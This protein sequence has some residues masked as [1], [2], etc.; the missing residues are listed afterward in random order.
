MKRYAI[1]LDM[2][3]A[4]VGWAV[5]ALDEEEKPIGIIDLG[6]RIFDAAEQPKTGASLAA[7]RREARGA[8]RRLR[9]H[10]HRNERIRGT[11]LR[12]GLLT[13]QEL[14]QLFDGQLEDIYALRV[15]A[16]DEPVSRQEFARILI[17]LSQH[18]G[19]RSNRRN[20]VDGED[21][22]L[23]T[24]VNE[25]KRIMETE[26]Y[27]TV[28]EMLLKDKRFEEH[29][30]NKGGDYISTVSRDMVE[31]EV[32][33]IFEAQRK[34]GADFADK[35]LESDYIEILLSQRSFDEG[36]GG[37]SPYGGNQIE[38]MIGECTFIEG[39]PR[40][41]KASYSFE[42]FSFLE[43]INH[44]RLVNGKESV[45]LSEAQRKKLIELAHKSDSLNYAKIRKELSIDD[46]YKFN[47]VRYDKSSEIVEAAEK[48]EKLVCLK[49]YHQMRKAINSL[50][51]DLFAQVTKEQRNTIA[52]VLS[53]YKSSEKIEAA[54]RAKGIE[55]WLID[56]AD[57]IGNFSGFG[58]LSIKACDMLIP[59]LE[60]GMN[61]NEACEAAGYNFK[62]HKSEEKSKY[63]KCCQED[64]EDI[65]SPVVRRSIAQTIKVL[66]AIIRKQDCSPVYI[67]V[68][69]G[70]ELAKNFQE[71][72][73][74]SKENEEN[75]KRN[76]AA[77][78]RLKS[79]YGLLNASGND[80]VKF[81][82]FQE[83]DGICPYSL[84]HIQ[85]EHLF[86]PGYAEVDHIV[87]YSI[88]FDNSYKNKV[89]VLAKENREK[90]NRLPMQY[91]TGQRKDDFV[92]WVNN[93]VKDY[94]KRQN[95]LKES[96]SEEEKKQ[97]KERSLQ[98]TK[99][100]SRFMMNL[101]NDRLL[102]A[103]STTGRKKRVTAVSG[104]ITSTLRSRWGIN[105]IRENGDTHHAVDAVVI[106][107]ATDG[108]IQQIS[109]NV[110]LRECQYMQHE[111]GSLAI[112][113]RTGEVFR[114]FPFPWPDFRRELDARL[115][116]D[117]ARVINDLKLPFYMNSGEPL[118]KPI[119]VSRMPKH[120][121]TGAAH[122]ET[123]KSGK[124]IE[125]G[126]VLVKR[127]LKDL[128]LKNGE[129]ENYYNPDSDRLLYEALKARL[130]EFNGNAEKAF[131]EPFYKPKRD[132]SQGPQVK[133]VKLVEKTTLNV[134]VQ[135]NQA[136]A[137]HDSMVRVDVF[138]IDGDGYY[139]VPIYVADTLKAELPNKACVAFKNYS[140]W[141]PMSDDNFVFS[142]Y[143]DDLIRVEH[144]KEMKFALTHK[145]SSLPPE[146]NT[147]DKLVYYTGMNI[148]TGNI[149]IETHD[150]AYKI[151]SLGVKTLRK[152]EKYTVDV[153]GEYHKVEKEKRMKFNIKN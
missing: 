42:Y 87:P 92:V 86:E 2:G 104:Q 37:N 151:G 109:R 123:V 18:R 108:M 43:K 35:A 7:P 106:A 13:K 22:K 137:D 82:L 72:N 3:V 79:E 9:R 116:N 20:A 75:N 54:L 91:L 1:G 120:K 150:G 69:L 89:L 76:E 46:D 12:Y 52:T 10:R 11:I 65:T 32:H 118:P 102:F 33:C 95:L 111:S 56:A 24:A 6:S 114:E 126:I 81:K 107:C 61:Y 96:I 5:L 136:V 34:F 15:R 127:S 139:L 26:A 149:S 121:V 122:K 80:L 36:P 93:N 44:I 25:N 48:K 112:D 41:A 49:A 147:K 19:F 14:D 28:G 124:H 117:P 88:S 152:F 131:A 78:E 99:Y 83:Q 105:K 39:E 84:K 141:K 31:D 98:D 47:M 57:K 138:Y 21:G 38:K 70:R 55:P 59:Y 142:L 74:I 144:K 145:E 64:F 68:E 16:L 62:V 77:M 45:P 94:R 140:E 73:K 125:E 30:R 110:R 27:R 128:K 85:I 100:A 63:L 153:L 143:A 51:K 115:A 50:S 133:T 103:E 67:N 132:G 29:K 53:L 134:P 90:G 23:L 113:S 60:Q 129:I 119:F 146:Y 8:R 4:S 40:A 71:R 148:A 97:W 101:I 135:N 17:N 58:H 66:N 130:Q